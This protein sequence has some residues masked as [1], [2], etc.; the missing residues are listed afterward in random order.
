MHK[1]HLHIATVYFIEASGF[2][3]HCG[4]SALSDVM[5][6]YVKASK[7]CECGEGP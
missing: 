2:G 6:I 1:R 4:R 7:K 5:A 3:N